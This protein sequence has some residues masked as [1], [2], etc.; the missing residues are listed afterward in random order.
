MAKLNI[1]ELLTYHEYWKETLPEAKA[2]DLIALS[3]ALCHK[4]VDTDGE[5]EGISLCSPDEC[6]DFFTLIAFA[7]LIN[8][9]YSAN[10][11]EPG[12]T[13]VTFK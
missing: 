6:K 11:D 3:K 12:K 10:M 7:N 9:P 2:N 4:A 13:I 8:N 5:L 1:T